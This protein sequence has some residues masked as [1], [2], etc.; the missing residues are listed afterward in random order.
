MRQAHGEPPSETDFGGAHKNS[1]LCSARSSVPHPICAAL[2]FQFSVFSFSVFQFF[3]FQFSVF[4]FQFS[5]FSFQFSVFSFQFSVFSFQYSVFSTQ[6]SVLSFQYSVFSTQFSV[7]SFQFSVLSTQYSVLSTRYSV[8]GSDDHICIPIR[9]SRFTL[10]FSLFEALVARHSST[11][12]IGHPASTR[13]R[14]LPLV[15]ARP[16]RDPDLT[17]RTGR[18]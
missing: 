3:S 6:F 10:R 9:Y 5:V 8:L 11:Q 12:L 16:A 2:S 14:A 15:F 4:S 18:L 7:F 1:W 13:R 17:S